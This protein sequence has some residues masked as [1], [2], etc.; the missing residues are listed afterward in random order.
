VYNIAKIKVNIDLKDTSRD[1]WNNV[2]RIINNM[3][4]DMGTG[5]ILIIAN[6]ETGEK[7]GLLLYGPGAS[8]SV[9]DMP[10]D[11]IREDIYTHKKQQ[12]PLDIPMSQIGENFYFNTEKIWVYIY[13]TN[14]SRIMSL[15][16][17]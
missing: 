10:T 3:Y 4:E 13:R 8:L 7:M 5:R 2:T 15:Y 16:E 17:L 6:T 11:T 14:R 1:I 12:I 9:L